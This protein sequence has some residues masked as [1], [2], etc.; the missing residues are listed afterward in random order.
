M[1]V[2]VLGWMFGWLLE[3]CD[4]CWDGGIAFPHFCRQ[5]TTKVRIT[6]ICQQMRAFVVYDD[7]SANYP[8]LSTNAR[9]CQFRTFVVAFIRKLN[10]NPFIFVGFYFV[11]F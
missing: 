5:R 2:S 8:L 11:G 3:C 4:G 9:I 7:K 6:H 1:V 10:E